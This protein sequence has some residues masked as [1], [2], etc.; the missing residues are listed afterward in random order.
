MKLGHKSKGY[1]VWV[2]WLAWCSRSLTRCRRA[3]L[4]TPGSSLTNYG[5]YSVVH[6]S[7]SANPPS[8][9]QCTFLP[10][11]SLHFTC[12]LTAELVIDLQSAPLL[13]VTIRLSH[14]SL[15]LNFIEA[16]TS[17]TM[18]SNVGLTDKIKTLNLFSA[19]HFAD[20]TIR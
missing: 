5:C 4:C 10:I 11:S 17:C 19:L 2:G 6:L 7:I 1:K 20:Q 14:H 3:L 16:L 8:F 15:D 13:P 18:C 12:F 9:P